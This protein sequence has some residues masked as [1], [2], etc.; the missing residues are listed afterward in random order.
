MSDFEI[1]FFFI[2]DKG[3]RLTQCSFPVIRKILLLLRFPNNSWLETS[4]NYNI[5]SSQSKFIIAMINNSITRTIIRT[6]PVTPVPRR[7]DQPKT[8]H[9]PIG[10]DGHK[11]LRKRRAQKLRQDGAFLN[12]PA[13][14]RLLQ[15]PQNH[16]SLPTQR[17]DIYIYPN[18]FHI[19]RL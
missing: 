16:H 11:V 3:W 7:D 12:I 4:Q 1:Q 2:E 8:K 9:S 19:I 14:F 10:L 13:N 5:Q 18:S 15:K 17:T 6:T